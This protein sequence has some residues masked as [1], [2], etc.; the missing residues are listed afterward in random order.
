MSTTN[1]TGEVLTSPINIS[2]INCIF[3]ACA[4]NIVGNVAATFDVQNADATTKN[5][6]SIRVNGELVTN[7][8]AKGIF[9]VFQDEDWSPEVFRAAFRRDESSTVTSVINNVPPST[10]TVI[11]Y[12]LEEDGL[13]ATT[14]SLE[15]NNTVQVEGK[16]GLFFMSYICVSFTFSIAEPT[17]ADSTAATIR[18]NGTAI[19]VV[20]HDSS[21]VLV[22]REYGSRSLLVDTISDTMV[23]PIGKSGNYTFSVFMMNGKHNISEEPVVTKR[24]EIQ[25][26][27]NDQGKNYSVIFCKCFLLLGVHCFR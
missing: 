17:M 13:P 25:P 9:I 11:V 27:K 23:K 12:D 3:N 10:Y 19:T 24:F 26:T 15:L 14:P 16:E 4:L 8:T 21:C 7:T 22:G 1:V 18:S 5:S 6:S 2:N 20:C